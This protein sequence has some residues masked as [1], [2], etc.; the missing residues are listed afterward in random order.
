MLTIKLT[1]WRLAAGRGTRLWVLCCLPIL[2]AW[3]GC[4]SVG[5]QAA[6]DRLLFY[7]VRTP[8]ATVFLLGSIHVARDDVYPLREDILAA[9]ESS[10]RLAVELDIVGPNAAQIQAEMLERGRY[11]DGRSLRDDL[12]D[13]VYTEL[14]ERLAENGLPMDLML[15]LKP[16]LVITT[17]ASIEM[18]KLGLNPEQGIDRF[19]LER[20]RGRKPIIELETV[21]QQLDALIDVPNPRLMVEQALDQLGDLETDMDAML[22]S[23]K[24]GDADTL[25]ALILETAI[26]DNPE[27]APIYKRLFDDRNLAMMEKLNDLVAQG[28]TTFLVVGAGHL[29]GK[30]GL[31]ALARRQGYAAQQK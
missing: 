27:Y 7:E 14:A 4:Y 8:S 28:G 12:D 21:D 2:F 17:L 25:A 26:A 31:I 30:Q 19:F 20:S 18:M 9:W 3:F 5:A 6:E 11:S 1:R 16:G 13:E 10:D 24:R 22:L 29:V 23:W 15:S